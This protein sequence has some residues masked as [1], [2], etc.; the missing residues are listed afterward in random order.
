[1]WMLLPVFCLAIVHI[2]GNNVAVIPDM[3][4]AL[5][6][7]TYIST[8]VAYIILGIIIAAITAWIGVRTSQ[9]L[10]VVARSIYGTRG[11]KVLAL[12]LLSIS[13]PAS[14]LTGGYYAGEIVHRL[15][16]I[17]YAV[18]AL[19][20]LALFSLLAVGYCHE[21]LKISNYIGLLLIPI[22]IFIF[23]LHDLQFNSVILK[24]DQVNWLL[25]LGLTGYNVGGM[26]SALVVE[27]AAYL[28]QKG[29]KAI[30][31]VILAKLVEGIFTLC[32]VYLVLSTGAQGPLALSAVV[33]KVGGELMI[34]IFDI[35][36]FCIFANT[37]A[38]AMLVNARQFSSLTG[39]S[40]WPALLLAASIVYVVSF[41][42]FSLILSIMGY[43]ALLMILFIIYTAYFLH[44]YGINQQ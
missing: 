36:L 40:F 42:N 1:M 20:C 11:K 10:V 37:M 43:T 24:G 14:A 38:P 6:H 35:V 2:S 21:L 3:A 28:S 16:G 5:D 29:S 4:G 7:D 23:F 26:W 39:L 13:I 8:I 32:M 34:D 44:K 25:V 31:L 15:T 18:A 22:L 12:A 41:L 19:A 30:L 17:P 9:D 27:T 33:S